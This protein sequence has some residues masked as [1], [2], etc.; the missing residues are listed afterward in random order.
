MRIIYADDDDAAT[1]ADADAAHDDASDMAQ[2]ARA[3][4]YTSRRRAVATTYEDAAIY[5]R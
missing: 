5:I 3:T 4:T 2:D 1:S